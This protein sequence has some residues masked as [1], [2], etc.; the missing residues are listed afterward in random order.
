MR[1]RFWHPRPARRGFSI[2]E[3]LIGITIL[4]VGFLP[5]YLLIA[6]GE[7][8]SVE[9]VRSV[10]ASMHAHT[11]LEEVAHLPYARIPAAPRTADTDFV[12]SFKGEKALAGWFGAVPEETRAAFDRSVE[13]IE[14]DGWKRIKVYVVDRSL[15]GASA[16]RR[17]ELLLETLVVR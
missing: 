14:G 17:G 16:G 10:Q 8:G 5:V 15:A 2:V 12:A 7:K 1:V 3:A 13:V 11:L 9:T 4:V 6:S